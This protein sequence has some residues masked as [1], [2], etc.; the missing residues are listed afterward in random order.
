[1]CHLEFDR[2]H[3]FCSLRDQAT[4]ILQ[5]TYTHSKNLALFVLAYKTLKV[6]LQQL[7]GKT[8]KHHAFVAA[9]IA[10]YFVF[11]TYNKV[12]EQVGTW[13]PFY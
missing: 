8:E 2:C 5:A 12:N 3:C 4:G 10:G 6:G 1:M 11:G 9:F 13:S 7:V